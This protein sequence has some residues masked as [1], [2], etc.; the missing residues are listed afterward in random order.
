MDRRVQEFDY[1]ASDD[2]G[3]VARCN[4]VISGKAQEHAGYKQFL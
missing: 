4:I 3:R 1:G 2:Q